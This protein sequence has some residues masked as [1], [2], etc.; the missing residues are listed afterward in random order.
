MY[1]LP[2]HPSLTTVDPL[3]ICDEIQERPVRHADVLEAILE[4]ASKAPDSPTFIT[5]LQDIAYTLHGDGKL[6]TGH[7]KLFLSQS[8]AHERLQTPITNLLK[9][10]KK[11][12]D[13]FPSGTL[14]TL[15]EHGGV[16]SLSGEEVNILLAHQ[17][18]GSLSKPV[19]NT[20]GLP[21]FTSWYR[22]DPAHF[23]AINGYLQT[24]FNHFEN[25]YPDSQMVSFEYFTSAKMP[26]LSQFDS[27]MCPDI[28]VKMVDEVF[29]PTASGVDRGLFVLVSANKEPGPGPTATHEERLQ[30]TS[31]ALSLSAIVTPILG[32]D[33]AVITSPLPVHASWRGHNR[34]ARLVK[35]FAPH[36]RPVRQY[37]LADAIALD[38][39]EDGPDGSLK[40]L[41]PGM[42]EREVRKLYASFSGARKVWKD[43]PDPCVIEAPAWGC[44]SFNG[45][46]IVKAMCMAIAAG[47]S[48]VMVE[49]TLERRRQK[50]AEM[51]QRILDSK[52]SISSIWKAMTSNKAESITDVS[53]LVD[54]ILGAGGNG[55]TLR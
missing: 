26:D 53:T 9:S 54:M 41:G 38:E 55:L 45:N 27:Q 20:W 19:S 31:L 11:L 33:A 32:E 23:Q 22:S 48:G 39:V 24:L 42:V 36:E 29:D 6:E 37:I 21:C 43:H 15:S 52:T 47:L 25:P 51:I 2:N 40:D 16:I 10:A 46:V 4:N 44:S 30:C 13:C 17:A 49:L 12:P 28:H 35:L 50:E 7:L 3:G 18:L 1:Y 34:S 14:S 5:L 8:V